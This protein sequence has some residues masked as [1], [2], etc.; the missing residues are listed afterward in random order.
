MKLL[1]SL[2]SD[3]PDGEELEG[4]GGVVRR[5]PSSLPGARN[6]VGRIRQPTKLQHQGFDAFPS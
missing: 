1:S 4:S 3:L 2:R 5:A 6:H